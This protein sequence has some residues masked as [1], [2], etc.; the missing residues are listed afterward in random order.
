MLRAIFCKACCDTTCSTRIGS[1]HSGSL[2]PENDVPS[3]PSTTWSRPIL[4]VSSCGV[5]LFLRRNF[6]SRIHRQGNS[7]NKKIMFC[8]SAIASILFPPH[9]RV[10]LEHH[11]GVVREIH[12]GKWLFAK[13][14]SSSCSSMFLLQRLFLKVFAICPV[15]PPPACQDPVDAG[16]K[17]HPPQKCEE[18]VQELSLTVGASAF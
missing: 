16:L 6:C 8:S 12:P 5:C 18:D 3:T 17:L 11:A 7:S 14:Q 1:I 9:H 10:K 15:V 2:H 13:C 4:G